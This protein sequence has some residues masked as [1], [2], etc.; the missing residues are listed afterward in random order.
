MAL[1]ALLTAACGKS[2]PAANP[3]FT[4]AWTQI[5]TVEFENFDQAVRLE[6]DVAGHWWQSP[7]LSK[8]RQSTDPTTTLAVSAQKI[9]AAGLTDFLTTLAVLELGAPIAQNTS[10]ETFAINAY[11]PQIRFY[12]RQNALL[13]TLYIGKKG[14]DQGSTYVMRNGDP[15]VY[16]TAADLRTPFLVL[17]TSWSENPNGATQEK[18]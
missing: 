18:N 13:A 17:L 11:S 1:L 4:F 14:S 16:W 5:Q 7:I 15:A 10:P 9:N 12:D 8:L 2:A 6:K 3:L